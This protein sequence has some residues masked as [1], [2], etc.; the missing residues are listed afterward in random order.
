MSGATGPPP[1]CCQR[2]PPMPTTDPSGTPLTLN[3][4]SPVPCLT[5]TALPLLANQAGYARISTGISM[6]V[7]ALLTALLEPLH[8]EHPAK[9]PLPPPGACHTPACLLRAC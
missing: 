4:C 6:I 3:S 9:V 1:L 7:L 5:E 8:H 2:P